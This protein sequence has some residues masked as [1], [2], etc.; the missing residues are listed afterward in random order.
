[1]RREDDAVFF[2]NNGKGRKF[3]GGVWVNP[4][5]TTSE[6]EALYQ[7]RLMK[8]TSR[9]DTEQPL[10]NLNDNAGEQRD[11]ITTEVQQTINGDSHTDNVMEQMNNETLADTPNTDQLPQST[12][13]DSLNTR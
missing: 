4:D 8:R 10:I 12:S 1:M 5:L 6:R 2:T 11:Q 7:K 13:R 3:P 9:R